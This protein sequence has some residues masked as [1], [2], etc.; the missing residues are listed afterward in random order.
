MSLFL[1]HHSSQRAFIRFCIRPKSAIPSY[2]HS[3]ILLYL[4]S[5]NLAVIFFRWP[6]ACFCACCCCWMKTV[7]I[8]FVDTYNK[9]SSN[10]SS[11]IHI[12]LR[13][14]HGKVKLLFGS[15]RSFYLNFVQ[16]L[17]FISPTPT[18]LAFT[19]ATN[20]LGLRPSQQQVSIMLSDDRNRK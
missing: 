9:I 4:C 19:G 3:F 1:P 16:R 20:A 18:L 14:P 13:I 2:L 11:L 17:F 12:L 7:T 15:L 6:C 8:A 10:N 5:S